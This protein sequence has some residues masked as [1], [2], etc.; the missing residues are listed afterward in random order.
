MSPSLSE[1][2]QNLTNLTIEDRNQAKKINREIDE[3]ISN[4]SQSSENFE[5]FK[6]LAEKTH[7]LLDLKIHLITDKSKKD[8]NIAVFNDTIE[9]LCNI[10]PFAKEEYLKF[11]KDADLD[12]ELSIK[13]NMSFEFATDRVFSDAINQNSEE[14]DEYIKKIGPAKKKLNETSKRKKQKK[15]SDIDEKKQTSGESIGSKIKRFFGNFFKKKKPEKIYVEQSPKAKNPLN[16]Q[17]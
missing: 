17:N 10:D 8:F 12:T 14:I 11:K 15:F 6:N 7:N 4:R 5:S 3:I 1:L 16:N 13:N 9:R 2:L